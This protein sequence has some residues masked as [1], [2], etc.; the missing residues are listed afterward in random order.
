MPYK[1]LVIPGDG[2]G[3]EVVE[4]ALYV[5]KSAAAK[6]GVDMEIKMAEAG[7]VALRKYG[8]AMPQEAL[9]LADAADVIFKGPIGESAYD[10]TSLIR[11]RYTLYANIRPVKNLPGVPAVREID[12]VFVRE[13]V[14]DVY[15]GAEYKVGDVAI[16]LKVI[17]EKGT[18][19]VA[20]MARKYAEMRR[21]RVTIVHK[22]NVLRVVDGFFRD[23]ALEELKGLEVDQMYVDAAAMELVRNPKRFDVVLTMN[24]YGDILTDLAAQVAGGIGLAPSGNIGDAKAM[25]EPVHG[26]AF[27]IAGRGVANPIATILSAAM[28]FEWMGRGDVAEKIRGAVEKSIEAGVK[29]PDIGG[30]KST[31]EVGKFIASIL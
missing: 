12:C 22:A 8:T 5:I 11:M 20:R 9:R 24:Q 1:I 27:D 6:Y 21:R 4:A 17:T 26:A 25:F 14:E 16:A 7:D 18:R 15:V 3:P 2:I 13:N 23:I 31:I 19:R 30:D 10:V 29:T 28:M